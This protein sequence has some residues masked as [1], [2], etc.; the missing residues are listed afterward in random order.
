MEA[1]Y[2]AEDLYIAFVAGKYFTEPQAGTPE[3][4]WKRNV[5]RALAVVVEENRAA[6]RSGVTTIQFEEWF[7]AAKASIAGER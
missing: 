4:S 2:T 5:A 1:R 6:N 7:S 3:E